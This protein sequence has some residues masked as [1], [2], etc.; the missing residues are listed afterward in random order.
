ME[1]RAVLLLEIPRFDL[2]LAMN[3]EHHS[4][5][6]GMLVKS[7]LTVAGGYVLSV[8]GLYGLAL[9]LASLFFPETLEA[10]GA[11]P[12]DFERQLADRP[13]TILPVAL[14]WPLVMLNAVFSF[15]LGYL[16]ARLAPFAKFPHCIFLAVILFVSF[17]QTAIG[18]PGALQWMIVLFM[19]SAPIA[20]LLGAR[21][22]VS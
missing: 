20:V 10:I 6:P 8:F 12:E 19:A 11:E 5:P 9:I 3:E 4:L 22:A 14:F 21:A 16:I 2:W 7:F 18:A 15:G 1:G 13:E 17:L